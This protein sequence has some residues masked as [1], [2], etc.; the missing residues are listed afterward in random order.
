VR[1]RDA[2]PADTAAKPKQKLICHGC[3]APVPYNVAKFCWFNKPKF[4]GD[5]YCMACQKTVVSS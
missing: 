5:L 2:L 1:A 3:S 4:G